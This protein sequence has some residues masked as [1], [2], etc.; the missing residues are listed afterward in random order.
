MYILVVVCEKLIAHHNRCPPECFGLRR[1][2]A[3]TVTLLST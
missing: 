2:N 1:S 3:T